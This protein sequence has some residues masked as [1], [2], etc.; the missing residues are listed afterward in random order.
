MIRIGG[1][2]CGF[3][4]GWIDRRH[5]LDLRW[6]RS[7]VRN[8]LGY[9]EFVFITRAPEIFVRCWR[10]RHCS[11]W[12]RIQPDVQR[13]LGFGDNDLQSRMPRSLGRCDDGN[14]GKHTCRD[15]CALADPEAGRRRRRR[16]PR[17]SCDV[18]KKR[19]LLLLL[20]FMLNGGYLRCVY[21]TCLRCRRNFGVRRSPPVAKKFRLVFPCEAGSGRRGRCCTLIRRLKAFALQIPV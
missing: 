16:F 15:D 7:S 9:G 19:R 1:I 20:S 6:I 11:Y 14:G 3:L 5:D 18:R 17:L 10:L 8:S 2:R 12:L 21:G 4:R 13:V